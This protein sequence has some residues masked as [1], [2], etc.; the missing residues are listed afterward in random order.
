MA[1]KL[2]RELNGEDSDQVLRI[3]RDLDA[4]LNARSYKEVF[5]D[6]ATAL[7]QPV[8]VPNFYPWKI[9]RPEKPRF[10]NSVV[11]EEPQLGP[12]R[13]KM[14]QQKDDGPQ[15]FTWV[16]TSSGWFRER[17]QSTNN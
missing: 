6:P 12:A 9:Q 17:N 3:Q 14:N 1:Q 11:P 7:L 15:K 4:S 8:I 13:F 5:D 10:Q 2:H 16:K